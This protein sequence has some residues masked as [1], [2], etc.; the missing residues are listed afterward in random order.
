MTQQ[1]ASGLT[2]IKTLYQRMHLPASAQSEKR[3]CHQKK[4]YECFTSEGTR[5]LFS[6]N[7]SQKQDAKNPSTTRVQLLLSRQIYVILQPKTGFSG[8]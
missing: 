6:F 3:N 7:L 1:A 5:G 8:L 2:S 4:Y